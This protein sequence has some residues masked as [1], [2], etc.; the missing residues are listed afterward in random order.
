MVQAKDRIEEAQNKLKRHK[1][2]QEE[3]RAGAGKKTWKDLFMY[4]PSPPLPSPP[5]C[6]L[7]PGACSCPFFS[8]SGHSVTPAPAYLRTPYVFGDFIAAFAIRP[9]PH[10]T[11]FAQRS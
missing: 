4:L 8:S 5:H 1:D 2:K 9:A 6:I 11:P 3:S 10:A 7:D